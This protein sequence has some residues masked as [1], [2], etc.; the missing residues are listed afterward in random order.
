MLL[1]QFR[2]AYAYTCIRRDGVT[3]KIMSKYKI[4]TNFLKSSNVLIIKSS[5]SKCPPI[6]FPQ[7]ASLLTVSANSINVHFL[8]F[9][10]GTILPVSSHYYTSAAGKHDCL[11]DHT[12]SGNE[13][14]PN[15]KHG[16]HTNVLK[17]LSSWWHINQHSVTR[18][19]ISLK[20]I[21]LC[22]WFLCMSLGNDFT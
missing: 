16:I 9:E 19:I 22:L 7:M 21:P 11:L 18:T 17:R 15:T 4:L 1:R 20:S 5:E 6:I 3:N 10:R 14:V 8:L 13:V 2:L 12:V